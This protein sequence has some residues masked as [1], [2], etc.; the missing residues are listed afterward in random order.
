MEDRTEEKG[1]IGE[2]RT[3]EEDCKGREGRKKRKKNRI[4][5]EEK[6]IV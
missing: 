5:E 3:E 4:L 1:M 6:S 2:K